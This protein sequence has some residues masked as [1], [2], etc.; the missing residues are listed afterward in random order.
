MIIF[1]LNIFANEKYTIIAKTLVP[2][3]KK[4][5]NLG[6][7]KKLKFIF[8]KNK[9]QIFFK[10]F[11]FVLGGL[12]NGIW[13][14]SVY[15]I[16]YKR[17]LFISAS[18][19][20]SKNVHNRSSRYANTNRIAGWKAQQDIFL[21]SFCVFTP[22]NAI[23]FGLLWRFSIVSGWDVFIEVY[24]SKSFTKCKWRVFPFIKIF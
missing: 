8:A 4:N 13:Y 11:R 16:K 3:N 21:L 15:R 17:K 9:K 1:N 5:N 20:W 22:L 23:C 14:H 19:C 12:C 7:H 2:L 18:V 6:I 10:L 24:R